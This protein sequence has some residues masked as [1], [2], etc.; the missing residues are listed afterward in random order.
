VGEVIY[1]FGGYELDTA[2]YELRGA[3]G[4]IPIEPRALDVLLHLVV[5]RDRAVTKEELLDSVWGDRFVSEAALTTALRTVRMAIGDSGKEQRLIRTVVRHGYQ[6]V[7]TIEQAASGSL[8][9]PDRGVPLPP[10]LAMSSGLGFA[11]R[12]HERALLRDAWKAAAEGELQ[13]VLVSGEAGIGKTTLCSVAAAAAH[14]EGAVVL[15]GRCDEELSIPYQPWR[16]VVA[17]LDQHL[18]EVLA[19]HREALATLMGGEGAADLD[20][21]SARFALNS[22]VVDVFEAVSSR[23]QPALVVLDDLHWADGPTLALVRH[24]VE[25]APATPAL[26]VGTFR[27]TDIDASHP[28]NGLLAATHREPGTSRVAVHGLDDGE[29]LDLLEAGAG[30]EMDDDGLALRD[31]LEAETEGNPFFVTEILRHLTE[32]G[33]IARHDDGR[34]TLPTDLQ[35]R[36]LPVSVREVVGR[37]V[38]RLGPDARTALETASVIG[39]D[40]ELDLLA[41][42][43]GEDPARTF[44][45]IA[46]AVDNALVIDAGARFAFTHAIVAHTLYA[47]LSPTAQAFGHRAAA[48]ALERRIGDDAGERAGEIAHHWVHAIGPQD[49]N[50]AAGHAQRAGDHA[51]THLA[52]DAAV[53]WYEQALE[54]LPSDHPT[55][56]CEILVG[57]GTAQRQA[58][59]PAYRET[60]LEASHGATDLARDD[61]LVRAALANNRGETSGFGVVDDERVEILQR[62]VAACP[63]G[64]D[65]AMLCAILAVEVH[66]ASA[67][68]AEEAAS[69]ALALA[70]AAGDDRVVVRVVRLAESA[71]RAPQE[72]P[73]RQQILREGIDAAARTGDPQLRGMLSISH[74]EL[75]LLSGDRDAMD[76]ERDIRDTFSQR[77]PEPFV[78]WTNA[79]TLATHL[80]LDGDLAGAEAAADAA[81][82]LGVATAQPEAFSGWAGQ[83]FE[84]RRAQDRLT[85]V[86]EAIEQIHLENPT[87]QVFR[88]ALAHVWCELGRTDEARALTDALDVSPDGAP[89][90]WA[91]SLMLWAEVCHALE[92]P[93]AAAQLI[94]FLDDWRDQVAS[95]GATTEG[96]IAHGLG[97]ALATVGRDDEAASAFDH[98]LEVNRRLRAPLFVARTQLAQAELIAG[99]DP[100]RARALATEATTVAER[101]GFS[102]ISRHA[103]ELLQLVG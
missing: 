8:P 54:L 26:V 87:L 52:P 60:L 73:R 71:L 22:A 99:T 55:E 81:F 89:Q 7:G 53:T 88:A 34:W 12:E 63:E 98:A 58:G 101:L 75:A 68:Q 57:L 92:L 16:E 91:T 5:H 1:A 90:Y 74:H 69:R 77:S 49:R 67:E 48:E 56:R 47:E 21:D 100:G 41:E 64:A 43:L 62:A 59:D 85:E 27:D 86:A 9:D 46:P 78:R 36:G 79:Q 35:V 50:K 96:A 33:A 20:S 15:Y 2:R 70:R 72:L 13:V 23:G 4:R 10:R 39:R 66:G 14:D 40:F 17:G 82:E 76:R 94:P 97:L 30:H 103:E 45:R 32:T 102:R 61:L 25:R 44:E 80:F 42:L 83:I 6:F 24:L 31:A 29:L 19:G 28:L 18:P 93:E 84:I 3:E 95:T 65:G 38:E 11:G 51:L 37:R